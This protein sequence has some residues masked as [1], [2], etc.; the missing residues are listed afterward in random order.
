MI[1]KYFSVPSPRPLETNFLVDIGT[2]FAMHQAGSY[3]IANR[4]IPKNSGGAQMIVAGT[5]AASGTITS[6]T[7]S[8][9]SR[10]ID[11]NADFV[12]DGIEPGDYVSVGGYDNFTQF[13][14][15]TS[16][17]S[18]TE[19]LINDPSPLINTGAGVDYR[20]YK[21]LSS[22][23]DRGVTTGYSNG[24][25]IDTNADFVAAG[26]QVGDT[27][28]NK[29]NGNVGLVTAI[30]SPTQLSV[31]ANFS[32]PGLFYEIIPFSDFSKPAEWLQNALEEAL[33]SPESIYELDF[34]DAPFNFVSF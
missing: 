27:V 10:F 9:N 23:I 26:V 24:K 19:L 14:Y 17:V 32:A 16:V 8:Q 30:D 33:D 1:K 13:F 2:S 29:Q 11:S 4:A 21:S 25:L 15:V 5:L 6:Y 28:T 7:Q 18:A 12:T 22:V 20:V 31:V 3:L 34:T